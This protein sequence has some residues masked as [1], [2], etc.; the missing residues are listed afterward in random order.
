MKQQKY[1]YNVCI[2]LYINDIYCIVYVYIHTHIYVYIINYV[3][4]NMDIFYGN[5]KNIY[6]MD[7][8]HYYAWGA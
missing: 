1:M 8:S 5:I 3:Q 6:N 4:S 7:L 2:C